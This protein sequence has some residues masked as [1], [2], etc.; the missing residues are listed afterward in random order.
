MRPQDRLRVRRAL[1]KRAQELEDDSV[2]RGELS[3]VP[4]LDVIT[5]LT[6]FLLATTS[7]VSM[8]SEVE[9]DTPHACRGCSGPP[10][11]LDLTV[12][13]T[14]TTIRVAGAGHQL[15]P[16][17]ATTGDASTPTIVRDGHEWDALRACATE[18]RAAFPHEHDVRLTADPQIPYEDTIAA[19]DA[20]RGTDAGPLFDDVLLAAGVR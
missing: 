1:R 7:M 13:V 12:V 6:I 18:V 2:G 20:L 10:P 17:C 19:M 5:N 15:A 16:G 3:I 9:A 8:S 14:A 4:L 11:S